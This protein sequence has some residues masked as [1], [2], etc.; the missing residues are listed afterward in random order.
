MVKK[1]W[2]RAVAGV[3]TL[4]MIVTLSAVPAFAEDA[5]FEPGTYEGTANSVGGP[6]RVSVEVSEDSIVSV[7]V[8]ECNDTQGAGTVAVEIVADRIVENQS[9]NVDGV[10]GA[11]LS[12]I[13]LRN[14]VRAALTEAGADSKQF[15]EKVEYAAPAQGDM[16][17]DVVVVGAGLAGESAAATAAMNGLNVV[18]LEKNGFL[19]GNS[20]ISD[21]AL[22]DGIG[23]PFLSQVDAVDAQ[24]V[25]Y[26]IPIEHV[27]V[28]YPGYGEMASWTL[29]EK[30]DMPNT[31]YLRDKLV[32]L[33]ESKGGLI[34]METPGIGLVT[35]DGKVTGVVAQPKGQEPFTIHAKAVIL[36]TGGF[37]A[38]EELV[39]EYLPYAS[40]AF[41][42]GLHGNMGDALAWV[43]E[44]DAD[45]IEMNASEASFYS[46]SPLG[47]TPSI[48]AAPH[49]YID[50][51]GKLIIDDTNYNKG[52]MEVYKA[53]GS[54]QYYVI[55]ADAEIQ[56]YGL[57]AGYD[58]LVLAG[59]TKRFE[60]IEEMATALDM[61]ELANTLAELGL[62]DGVYY[63]GLSTAGVYGTYGGLNTDDAARV[64]NTSG[65]AIPGLYAAG[66]V[67]GNRAFQGNGT[68]A[69]GVAP[70]MLV[71]VIAGNTVLADITK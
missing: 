13:F 66:E 71:G 20:I 10:T 25:G 6:L 46:M 53:I 22:S 47:Y 56:P 54:E 9:T 18:L 55:T 37:S 58:H 11:T 3:I 67:I 65:E 35:E 48:S 63:A 15:N 52:T 50:K 27:F 29:P 8:V 30:G 68:Y 38:N 17:V 28:E 40:G 12:S 1:S 5:K 36:A 32:E 44:L 39:A 21:Q 70:G 69:G 16:D 64:L 60:S 24:L 57:G 45:L 34:L 7:E 43:K 4:M 19:G 41:K 14:A 62:E 26:G 61:P 33:I 59:S 51:S 2:K 31:V 49:H 42:V 23:D